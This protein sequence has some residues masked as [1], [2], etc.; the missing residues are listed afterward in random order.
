MK[1]HNFL[2]LLLKKVCK[3][4]AGGLSSTFI[5]SQEHYV[6]KRLP[7]VPTEF[8]QFLHYCY[9]L[10]ALDCD[11]ASKP[12]PAYAVAPH[13]YKRDLQHVQVASVCYCI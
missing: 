11:C 2:A 13:M 9:V 8:L 10:L 7:R 4:A 3:G 1:S 12:W 6:K 5:A